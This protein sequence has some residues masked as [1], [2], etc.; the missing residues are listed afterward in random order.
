MYGGFMEST[1]VYI[2]ER[3]KNGEYYIGSAK[4]VDLRLKQHNAGYVKATKNK[5]PYKIVFFQEFET[6]EIAE[7]IEKKLKKMKRR[8]YLE[9]IVG[10]G[11]LK[12]KS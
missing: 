12:I 7:K 9:K 4:D 11:Y 5:R 10:D 6:E 3:C 1:S 8:D 2:L